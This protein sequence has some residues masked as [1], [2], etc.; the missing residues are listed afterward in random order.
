MFNHTIVDA[1]GYARVYAQRNPIDACTDVA[2]YYG[3]SVASLARFLITM[4]VAVLADAE[5]LSL[6]A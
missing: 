6:I 2:D 5:R 4:R 3:I 1:Y